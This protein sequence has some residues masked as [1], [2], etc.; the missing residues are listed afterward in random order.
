MEILDQFL[1]LPTLIFCITIYVCVYVQRILVELLVPKL[2]TTKIWRSLLLP[3]GPVGTG[4][5][6][7]YLF[8]SF[9]FP[10]QFATGNSKICY[11]L[12]CGL[13]S[14][15][16]YKILKEML[17]KR[18]A[19]LLPLPEFPAVDNSKKQEEKIDKAA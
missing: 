15:A 11:G 14:S 4:M 16:A 10:E 6:L 12:F 17:I 9:A 18:D 3:L 13:L 2:E 5:L 7:A 19:N 8:H 1:T